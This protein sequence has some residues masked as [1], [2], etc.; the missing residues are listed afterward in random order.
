MVLNLTDSMHSIPTECSQAHVGHPG[1]TNFDTLLSR[2]KLGKRFYTFDMFLIRYISIWYF[3]TSFHT[4]FIQFQ[5]DFLSLIIIWHTFECIIVYLIHF[6]NSVSKLYQKW[7]KTRTRCPIV[8]SSNCIEVQPG[9][10]LLM[11]KWH[12]LRL[13]LA[14]SH[15]RNSFMFLNCPGF[16]MWYSKWLH[17]STFFICVSKA[18]IT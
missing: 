14:F 7:I 1:C 2:S 9:H 3:F 6:W 12:N 10:T 18:V 16:G 8:I 15:A 4:H 13:N 17:S 11:I 5:C